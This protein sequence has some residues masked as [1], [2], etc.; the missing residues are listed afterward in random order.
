MTDHEKSE[1]AGVVA[2]LRQAYQHLIGGTVKNQKMFAE[3]LIAPQI[4]RLER[5]Q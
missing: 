5:L 1:I 2:Q 4:R 3:G